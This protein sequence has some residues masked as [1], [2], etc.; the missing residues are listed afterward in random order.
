MS[1]MYHIQF[2]EAYTVLSDASVG[3]QTIQM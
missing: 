3:R 2:A 1:I